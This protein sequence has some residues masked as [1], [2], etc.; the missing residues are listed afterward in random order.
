LLDSSPPVLIAQVRTSCVS[1]GAIDHIAA[2][3]SLIFAAEKWWASAA[4]NAVPALV[5]SQ[6]ESRPKRLALA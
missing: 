4:I 3:I 1:G 6:G 5:Q 2:R